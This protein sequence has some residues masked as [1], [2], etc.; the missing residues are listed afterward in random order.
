MN[1][2]EGVQKQKPLKS[3]DLR[4]FNSICNSTGGERGSDAFIIVPVNT[5][6]YNIL[7]KQGHL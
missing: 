6:L 7:L 5:G 4:G 1:I 3:Y 2:L